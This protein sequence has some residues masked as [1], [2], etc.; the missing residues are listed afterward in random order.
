MKIVQL[1]VSILLSLSIMACGTTNSETA[2][3]DQIVKNVDAKE[4]G[5]LISENADAI[6]ID[7]RTKDELAGG[8]WIGA[9]AN[10]RL[11]CLL[12][13]GFV[14]HEPFGE[15]R[16]SRGVVVTD[17]LT[18]ENIILKIKEYNLIN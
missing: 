2:G 3:Q 17:L 1:A 14:A 15:Y 6:I 11:I 16:M 9:S 7:V 18:T 8:T 12:N 13:G 4:M 10:K 5:Q